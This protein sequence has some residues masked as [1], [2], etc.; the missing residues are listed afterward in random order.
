MK[1][2][3]ARAALL[4]PAGAGADSI[5]ECGDF[6]LENAYQR[7]QRICRGYRGWRKVLDNGRCSR[8][9]GCSRD[10]RFQSITDY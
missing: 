2:I 5:R 10:I 7:H 8:M 6:S 1:T 4:A 3:L 9:S